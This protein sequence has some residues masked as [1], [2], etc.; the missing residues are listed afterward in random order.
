VPVREEYY[1][2]KGDLI[3]LLTLSRIKYLHDRNYPSYWKMQTLNR[4]DHYTEMNI[5][6]IKFNVA[7]PEGTFSLKNLGR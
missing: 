2:D 5:K 4:R 7:I 6:D 1:S 3:K